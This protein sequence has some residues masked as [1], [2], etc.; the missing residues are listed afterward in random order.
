MDLSVN[1]GLWTV[2]NSGSG[3]MVDYDWF[4]PGEEWSD[5]SI[6]DVDVVSVF[7]LDLNASV[8]VLSPGDVSIR[9]MLGLKTEF[10]EWEER[11]LQGQFYL[12]F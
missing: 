4:I 9:A 1:L 10:W 7:L 3:G 5:W 8:E 2:I 12:R 6:S 11:K